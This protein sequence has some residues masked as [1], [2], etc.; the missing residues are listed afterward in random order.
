MK[1][2]IHILAIFTMLLTFF[3]IFVGALIKSTEA[4]LSV[5]DWP[6]TFGQNMFLFPYSSMVGGIFYEHS[7]RLIASLVGFC[8]LLNTILIQF[9]NFYKFV[10]I[11]SIISLC[12]VITQGILGG[13]TVLY[14]LPAWLSASHGTLG[15]T[16][17]CL[18]IVLAI[19]T[20]PKWTK[21]NSSKLNYKIKRLSFISVA[22]VWFQLIIGAV[23]RHTESALVALDFPKINNAW[24]PSLKD[25]AIE[26]INYERFVQNFE[27]ILNLEPIT[28]GQ[29][30]IHFIH[31][32]FG[33]IIFL[34]MVYYCFNLYKKSSFKTTPII[35]IVLIIT[36]IA[37][38]ALTVLSKKEFIITSLH[39]SNGAAILGILVYLCLNINKSKLL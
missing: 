31:R 14:F 5:P 3:L 38:G 35:L 10:K 8:I 15:Q 28:S 26:K 7:H 1:K 2:L 12:A 18:T 23:V 30:L 24:I 39:V 29:L 32:S 33:Y 27:F 19:I 16:T 4:G 13:L 25:D 22:L 21:E 20:S 9:S 6:T 17:F 36:Q 11:I 37:L 34:F